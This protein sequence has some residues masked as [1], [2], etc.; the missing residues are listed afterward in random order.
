MMVS[1][2]GDKMIRRLQTRLWHRAVYLTWLWETTDMASLLC[3]PWGNHLWVHLRFWCPAFLAPRTFRVSCEIWETWWTVATYHTILDRLK[4]M[5]NNLQDADVLK[6]KKKKTQQLF[7][8][9]LKNKVEGPLGLIRKGKYGRYMV[10]SFWH[11]FLWIWHSLL[12]IL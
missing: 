2:E 1:F 6:K 8:A 11:S 4:R 5:V 12:C 10:S 3:V 9:L 7:N